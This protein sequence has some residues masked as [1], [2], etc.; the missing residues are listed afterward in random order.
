VNDTRVFFNK[1]ETKSTFKELRYSNITVDQLLDWSAPIDVAERY[2][3]YLEHSFVDDPSSEEVFYK[4]RDRWFGARCEYSFDLGSISSID[5][6][7]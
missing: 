7:I 2:L 4:C 1:H 5:K 6:V 3:L